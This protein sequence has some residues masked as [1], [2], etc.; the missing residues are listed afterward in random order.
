MSGWVL[1]AAWAVGTSFADEWVGASAH[2][3]PNFMRRDA[4]GQMGRWQWC[5]WGRDQRHLMIA[6][7]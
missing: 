1:H 3:G 6:L 4:I 7:S 2:T 5:A